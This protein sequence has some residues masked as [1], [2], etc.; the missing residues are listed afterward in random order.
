MSM[1]ANMIEAAARHRPIARGRDSAPRIVSE[2][3]PAENRLQAAVP[4]E[5]TR[6]DEDLPC[7]D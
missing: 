4:R 5:G 3:A 7:T 2:H 1:Q 6:D